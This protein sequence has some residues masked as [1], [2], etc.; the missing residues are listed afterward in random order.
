M[1]RMPTNPAE[2]AMQI[3]KD[4]EIMNQVRQQMDAEEKEVRKKV[5]EKKEDAAKADAEGDTLDRILKCLD[6]FT[7]KLDSVSARMDAYDAKKDGAEAAALDKHK[8]DGEVEEKGDPKELKSDSRSDSLYDQ[9]LSR[10]DSDENRDALSEVQSR[11]DYACS[12]W[13]RAVERPFNNEPVDSYRRRTARYHQ[14][15]SPAWKAVD[16]K[17]LS[18]KGLA[19]AADQIFSDSA[20]ASSSNDSFVGADQLRMVRKVNPDTGHVSREYYG[21]PSSWMSQFMMPRMRA[22]F[23]MEAI[24]KSMRNS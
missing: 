18:G 10:A 8:K 6:S 2:K 13:G 12:A 23:D 15:H 11:A 24:K 3:A 19:V 22:R 5:E 17:T 9:H 1:L 20:A 7:S 14:E 16:L 21:N 4:I